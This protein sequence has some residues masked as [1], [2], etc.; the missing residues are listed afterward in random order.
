MS[1][2]TVAAKKFG[3]FMKRNAFYFMIVLCIASVATVIALAVT[4]NFNSTPTPGV[5]D[6]GTDPG[7]VDPGTVD[8]GTDPGTVDP[9]GDDPVVK[10]ELKFIL[11]T[12]GSIVNDYS[13]S[14]L[15]WN[16]TLGQYSVHTGLDF[17]GTDLSVYAVEKGTIAEVGHDDLEGH[18][19]VI[20]HDEGYQSRYY[21]LDENISVKVGANVIKGQLIG[22]MSDTMG[23]EC[24]TG[25]HLHFEMSK[26]NVDIN[27]LE[28]LVLEEK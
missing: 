15:V 13:D 25:N 3:G 11:P 24:L 18:Y 22:T 12:S 1:K 6:P 2:I 5:V 26:N 17:T 14:V 10:P 8:P 7:T 9:G 20:N 27:P 23:A 4:G 21:S 28:V 19:V 16:D